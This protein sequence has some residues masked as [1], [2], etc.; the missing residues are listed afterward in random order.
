MAEYTGITV[1]MYVAIAPK[2]SVSEFMLYLKGR[3]TLMILTGIWNTVRNVGGGISGQEDIYVAIVGNVNEET[4][5]N[6][7]RE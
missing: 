5:L 3:S 2:L 4:I 6:N 1:Y 7:I